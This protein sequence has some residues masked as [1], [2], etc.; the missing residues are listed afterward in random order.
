MTGHPRQTAPE[1][2]ARPGGLHPCVRW[3][4]ALVLCL[5]LTGIIGL[6]TARALNVYSDYF[7]TLSARPLAMG[8]A[9]TA[10][11]DPS[12][13]FTN[14]AG[15]AGADAITLLYNHSCRHFPGSQEGGRNEWDQLDGDT[16]ALVVPLPFT[17]FAHGFTFDHEMGYDFRWH[18]ADGSLGYP[19]QR[20][21]GQEDV[22]AVAFHAGL[23][24]AIGAGVRRS[25][26]RF[27]PVVGN[28][29]QQAWFR[30]GE[31]MHLGI[32]A[33]VWPGL[34]Y[35]QSHLKLD[36]EWVL[37]EDPG[38]GNNALTV[39]Y[40]DHITER[41]GWALHPVGWLTLTSDQVHEDHSFS[42]GDKHDPFCLTG[43]G[44]IHSGDRQVDRLHRGAELCLGQAAR[45]RGG[46][47][48]GHRTWGFGVNLGGLWLNYTEI[49][50]MLPEII[51][52]GDGY[53][54][55]HFYGF[56]LELF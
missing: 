28:D 20:F 31:G 4:A 2:A 16:E 27:K 21:C 47:Y 48:D 1:A 49:E 13:V 53:E 46:N 19:R 12:A 15:L 32:L 24:I 23:P 38:A 37:L 25:T 22:D 30:Q 35:G 8:G 51:G 17:T 6:N 56:Q 14:P 41:R 36:Y 40:S 50:D 18:P 42:T 34:D 3:L 26:G 44:T 54:D 7:V 11:Y 9:C 29:Q 39:F 33:R 43:L 10:L 55:L 52:A 5:G 45:L